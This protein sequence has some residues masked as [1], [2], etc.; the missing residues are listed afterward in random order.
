MAEIQVKIIKPQDGYQM[1]ALSSPADI[2]IGGGAAGVGKTYTLLLE[3]LRHK[4]VKGFGTVIFR[5]TSPQIKA[6]GALWDTSMNIYSNISGAIPRESS[7]EWTFG[8]TSK[9]KF[10][11][12]EYEKNK[13]DWQGSQIPFI[14]FDELPHFTKSMFFYMLTRN[15]SVCG[16]KPYVRATCNPDPDSWVAELISWWIDPETGFPISE[17]NGVIRFFIAD[18]DNYIWGDTKDE[19]IEKSAFKF[20]RV[21][22]KTDIDLNEFIKSITFISGDIYENKEL[23]SVD[24]A[25]L[26]NLMSQDE[27]T[28]AA[29]LHGNW[30]QIISDQDVYEY[31]A[32]L[33]MFNNLYDVDKRG[34][35]ITA[36]IALKGSDKFVVG[37]WEGYSLEDIIIRDKSDGKMVIDDLTS[38]ARKYSVSNYHITY[39]NDGVGGFVDGFIEDAIPF[40]NGGAALVN[41]NTPVTING[42]KPDNYQNLKTQ[43]YYLSGDNVNLGKYSISEKV[44]NMMYDD[45]STV[46]Q[47]FMF[48]RKAIKR[49]KTDMDGKLRIIGKDE[50]KAKLNG[51]SPDLM[52]MFMMR[53][54]FN[55][56]I[57]IKPTKSK[58]P[59]V[60]RQII[61]EDIDFVR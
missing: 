6:E 8:E 34:R 30:K 53:E 16:V 15:R 1:M 29:L 22:E 27:E 58:L 17:R 45:K 46:R 20:E 61:S 25:Y 57:D 9:L 14:G 33:G 3:P 35:Y 32:F 43:C 23:L 4:D 38:F 52:D 12:M 39:D 49:S 55:L 42:K 37:Y 7:N 44:A 56:I 41:P 2:V 51:Q 50:M 11:H 10:S 60:G 48:E 5:R 31:H 59:Y 26:G 19:V 28:Q 18:G 40:L 36:D 13:F 54:R 24:P 47:R 21:K